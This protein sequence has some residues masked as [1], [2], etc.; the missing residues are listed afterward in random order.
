MRSV[1][2]LALEV[3]QGCRQREGYAAELIDAVA[4]GSG[5]RLGAVS[6]EA[7]P[8]TMPLTPLDR[9]FLMQLVYGVLRQQGTLDALLKP[10][11]QRPMNRVEPRLWEVLR[12]GAYQLGYLTQVPRYAAVS[13]TV[14]LAGIVGRPQARGF[15]NGVLRRLAEVITDEFCPRPA[16]D[17]LPLD[18][19]AID[20]SAEGG[21]TG[22][23]R[24]LAR[25]I[26]PDPLSH[27]LDYLAQGFSWPMWLTRRWYERFGFE[28]CLRLGF[29]FNSPPPL[30][31]RVN[32]LR[33]D[34]ETYRLRLAAVGIDARPGEHPQ[35]LRILTPLP[36]PEL[37]G[38]AEGDFTVQDHTSMLVASALAPQPGMRVLD[39]CAAPGGKTTHL[40][41][42][43]DHRGMVT[44]C[45]VDE[46]RLGTLT[47]L[48]HRLGMRG[49]EVVHL[50]AGESPPAGPFDAALVDVPCS[51]TGVLGRR[52]EVRWRLQPRQLPHLVREQTRLLLEALDRVRPG[53]VVVYATCS[54]E[55]EENAGVIAA[56]ERG[57]RGVKREAEHQAIPGRPS[58][59][60]YWARLR[61]S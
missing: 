6:A 56:V 4:S 46:A 7:G 10:F 23:Y 9:R 17:A 37:P 26:L 3:L 42:L 54:I 51:N 41:E 49:V 32:K 40:V 61:K 27:P 60:G 19:P 31:I 53:G 55:P 13:E 28:E 16:A 39:M 14:G 8:L 33:T 50:Q 34:R 43:M 12:L 5:P 35:S 24:R 22:R 38:Y 29:W 21:V 30:W 57:Y 47:S 45:D 36:I 48:C 20:S 44:A 2:A 1:R 18:L 59:G 52:P 58:D 25:P 15:V 11:V